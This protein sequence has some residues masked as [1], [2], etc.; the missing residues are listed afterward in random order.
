MH[1]STANAIRAFCATKLE[2]ELVVTIVPN[3][4]KLESQDVLDGG[5]WQA[6]SLLISSSWMA[7]EA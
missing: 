6:K 1:H 5:A 4:G 7:A 3:L 2:G